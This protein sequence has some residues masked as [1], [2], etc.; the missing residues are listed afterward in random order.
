MKK[1]DIEGCP[2]SF[3]RYVTNRFLHEFWRMLQE[4]T[5]VD[6]VQVRK[7]KNYGEIIH[8]GMS[9]VHCVQSPSYVTSPQQIPLHGIRLVLDLCR[10]GK[11]RTKEK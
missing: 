1:C 2:G 11:L 5:S 4:Q 8:R 7:G 9:T 10:L 6:S 3:Q